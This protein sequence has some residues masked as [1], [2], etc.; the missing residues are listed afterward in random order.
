[1]NRFLSFLKK[2]NKNKHHGYCAPLQRIALHEAAHAILIYKFGFT[3]D[4]VTIKCDGYNCGKIVR[5]SP[6]TLPEDLEKFSLMI[7][8]GPVA[9][10]KVANWDYVF[11]CMGDFYQLRD[12]I[13]QCYPHCIMKEII[14]KYTKRATIMVEENWPLIEKLA[15][16]LLKKKTLT[17][18]QMVKALFKQELKKAA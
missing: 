3:F 17:Y 16:I 9:S 18:N 7:L 12:N 8:A 1:M 2:N 14:S 11:D 4:F 6:Y 10:N 13:I 15:Q 5:L